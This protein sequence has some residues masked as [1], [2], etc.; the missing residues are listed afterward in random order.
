MTITILDGIASEAE[1][2]FLDDVRRE[3]RFQ[4]KEKDTLLGVLSQAIDKKLLP[5]KL[6]HAVETAAGSH[7]GLVGGKA[8]GY[9]ERRALA[10]D[11]MKK[12]FRNPA[13][14]GDLMFEVFEALIA[15][16]DS[17]QA[18]AKAV[19]VPTKDDKEK[20]EKDKDT[21]GGMNDMI[22][23]DS[24]KLSKFFHEQF[25]EFAPGAIPVVYQA[26]KDWAF[27]TEENKKMYLEVRNL[28]GKEPPGSWFEGPG[29]A[30]VK[31][32][33]ETAARLVLQQAVK[34][35]SN[36]D[37]PMEKVEK[38]TLPGE[39]GEI[40]RNVSKQL[41]KTFAH[42]HTVEKQLARASGG[43]GGG[44]GNPVVGGGRGG[45]FRARG[46]RGGRGDWGGG[47][48]GGRDLKDVCHNCHEPGH[49]ARDCKNPTYCYE[50]GTKAGHIANDCPKRHAAKAAKLG[51][52]AAPAGPKGT[53]NK[54]GS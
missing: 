27:L 40:T 24:T 17:A 48:G 19:P 51:E 46:G 3:L 49:L 15:K 54:K 20:D 11:L 21:R 4:C 5:K 32:F 13:V 41:G 22:G 53:K 6:L 26:I 44:G 7:Q 35:G 23:S 8:L 52:P 31:K 2:A 42:D 47:R 28:K 10:D 38:A 30:H 16:E 14:T 36:R 33:L 12:N 34:I 25:D 37:V 45:G 1:K 39:W 50:C 43:G 9:T 18:A 29:G